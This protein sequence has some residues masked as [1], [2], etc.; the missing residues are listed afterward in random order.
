MTAV[1]TLARHSMWRFILATAA[2]VFGI[3]LASG[4][5][6]SSA[7]AQS[8][9]VY[10]S[11][12]IAV[13]D[14]RQLTAY[15]PLSP[16][17]VTWSVNGIAG[18]NETV[19][20]VS[21]AGLYRS[22]AAVPSPS[23]VTVTATST[24]YP[25]KSA[26][27]TLTITQKVV[28]LWSISPTSTPVGSYTIRI[29][30]AN[31]TKDTVVYAGDEPL[32]TT[33]ASST[34][35]TAAG[36]VVAAQAGKKINITVRNPGLGGTTSSAVQLSVTSGGDGSSTTPA[37][38]SVSLSPSTSSVNAGGTVQFTA[39][40]RG[41]DNTAVTYTVAD[42]LNGNETVGTITPAGLYTA[43]KKVPGTNPVTIRATSAASGTATAVATVSIVGPPDPGPGQGTANL[44]AGR[45]LEQAAFGPTPSELA[46]VKQM[47]F[48]AWLNEQFAMPE[49][50]IPMP[51]EGNLQNADLRAQYLNRLSAAP[52]QL[53]Q[54]VS[55]ALGNI[56]VISMNKNIYPNEII[57][58]L[59]ILSRNA[60]GNYRTL[61]DEITTSS[62][63]GKYLD[64]ANSRKPGPQG[65]ANENYP[66][67]LMQ[68]FSLG[69]VMLNPDGT[70]KLDDNGKTISVYDQNTVAQVALALTGW[71]FPGPQNNN[72]E[73]FSGPMKP[74][75]AN[76]DMTEKNF[77]G[78]KLFAG[79][80]TV[81][82]KDQTLDCIFKHPNIAP[83]IS[84]R[85]IRAL[86]TSNPTPPYVAR[87]SAVFEN[88]GAGVR[89]DLK[90]V[91]RAILMD[92]EARN[93]AA[94]LQGGKLKDAIYH[95]TAF[96]RALNGRITPTNQLT[97]TFTQMAQ[98]PLAPPSVFGFYSPLYRIKSGIV[99]PEFQ[100]YTPTESV[101]RGNA[102]WQMISN[103]G[104]DFAIDLTPFSSVAGDTQ[105][106]IDAVDQA[107]L[108]GRMSPGLRQ[109][110]ANAVAAQQ[111]ATSRWQIALYLGA[112]SGAY[113]VQY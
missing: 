40:V 39:S 50:D 18:G 96:S 11:G 33:Y 59:Q 103:P 53:R 43:P 75:D 79:Q 31:L 34:S 47:G 38:I 37:P 86:V 5:T 64:M 54:R 109:Q 95:I 9:T 99:G 92:P 107:L 51:A 36:T 76:H 15:V 105:K 29:N 91:V 41:T 21:S 17:T 113:T 74:V 85:L 67:E 32:K 16:N 28:Q 49:T 108:Y 56:I 87:I 45:F 69:L 24:A 35:V 26:S 55:Y 30:G 66:R 4:F 110:I 100:I 102:L 7:H 93:D 104:G 101:L 89:G 68:L 98:T 46:R 60:F 3:A 62:Q 2:A 12:S 70:P 10:S 44:S 83:F 8:I 6:S 94:T 58:Y 71:T 52:D 13:A 57:P 25:E 90:A 80:G 88:N 19:G 111:D 82:D 14:T 106:L 73:N 77:L 78:C 72:W 81:L 27:V 61:L 22:P 42:V 97:W 23:A 48:D 20:T 112:L 65:G 1:R 63:M 84:V